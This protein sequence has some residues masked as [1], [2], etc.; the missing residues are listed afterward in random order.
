MWENIIQKKLGIVF[1]RK[2]PIQKWNFEKFVSADYL[3]KNHKQFGEKKN[4]NSEENSTLF[5][6][7]EYLPWLLLKLL[8]FTSVSRCLLTCVVQSS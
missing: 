6:N 8:K 7:L 4:S 1:Y 3:L 5:L 2:T